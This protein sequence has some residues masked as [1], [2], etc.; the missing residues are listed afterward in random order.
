MDG[1]GL[2]PLK[3]TGNMDENWKTWR[4]RFEIYATATE[5]DAKEE[6][7]QCAQLLH[8]MGEEA[9]NI[10][11]TFQ[12]KETE[13]NKIKVLKEKFNAYFVPKKNIAYERY[14]LFTSRQNERPLEE[15][16]REL[17]NQANQCELGTLAGELTTTMVI[18]GIQDEATR[19]K[20]LQMSDISLE[21]AVE[22]CIL[23]EKAREQ[24][25][26]MQGGSGGGG[27]GSVDAVSRQQHNQRRKMHT[28]DSTA[29]KCSKCGKN[30][31]LYK[32][33]AY[34]KSCYKCKKL[35]HFSEVCRETNI[36]MIQDENQIEI[37]SIYEVN[38]INSC[39]VNLKIRECAI[40][41]KVDTGANANII[42]KR[43]LRSMQ[44]NFDSLE[45][46]SDVLV[47]YTNETIQIY[48]T[49]TLKVNYDSKI[50]DNIKF[51]VC[52]SR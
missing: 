1:R 8:Y 39:T 11:N 50:Y 32:C 19:G 9:I 7:I 26:Q 14:K 48:G 38:K 4:Q 34:G 10:Y 3:M 31:P 16:I 24:L 28:W 44:F 23:T 51:Y 47:S 12:F 43:D 5:L 13:K 37:N 49:C 2:N 20:L 30:H 35:N 36:N 21:K 22:V 29:R 18:I 46:T 6:N 25:R 27:D 45:K 15:F 41:F 33:P 52:D 42:N 40:N 17:K